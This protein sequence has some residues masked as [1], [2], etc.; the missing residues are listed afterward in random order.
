MTTQ[1]TGGCGKSG[2]TRAEKK[3]LAT[4]ALCDSTS[5][6]NKNEG[7]RE[8]AIVAIA[9]AREHMALG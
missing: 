5:A 9:Q 1:N 6:Q 8:V 7:R 3:P 2:K 4:S